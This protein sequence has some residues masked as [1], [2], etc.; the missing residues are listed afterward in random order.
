MVPKALTPTARVASQECIAT[1]TID[2]LTMNRLPSPVLTAPFFA[3]PWR[4]LLVRRMRY[5][6]WLKFLGVCVFMWLFFIGYFH[7]LRNPQHEIVVMPLTWLDHAVDF[8]PEALWIYVSLWVYVGVAPGL[9]GSFRDLLLYTLWI[10]TLC[11]AG[12]ACFHFWPTAVPRPALE[13]SGYPGFALLQGVDAA[14]NACPSLHVATA[15]FTALWVDHVL[16]RTGAPWWLRGCNGV[17]VG[18]IVWSTMA[19][20]QHVAWDVAGGLLLALLFAALS[21]AGRRRN[22]GPLA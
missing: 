11:L 18:A 17:W 21:L 1:A 7:T 13:L 14:G 15:A 3:A 9:L 10:G 19:T 2:A 8:R 22:S 20:K 16:Q 5:L 12:L 4:A 6:W